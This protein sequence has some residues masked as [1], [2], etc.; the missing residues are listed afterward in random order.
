M[1]DLKTM[2]A[3]RLITEKDLF[4]AFSFYAFKSISDQPYN[5]VELRIQFQEWFENLLKTKKN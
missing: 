1:K 5:E 3:K 4:E 2:G